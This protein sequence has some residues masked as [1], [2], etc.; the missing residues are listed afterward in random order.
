VSVRFLVRFFRTRT[1]VPFAIHSL[2]V[3]I[4]GIVH[5]A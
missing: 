2:V 3:G 4:V 5:L 1:L